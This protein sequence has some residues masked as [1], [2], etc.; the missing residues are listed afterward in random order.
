MEKM[1]YKWDRDKA[2]LKKQQAKEKEKAS[3]Q[4]RKLLLK[5]IQDN[6]KLMREYEANIDGIREYIEMIK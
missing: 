4:K 5:K 3:N 6:D 1:Q 2:L